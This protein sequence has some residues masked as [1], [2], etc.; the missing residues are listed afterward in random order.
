MSLT[1]KVNRI[2]AKVFLDDE[3][4]LFFQ[5]TYN[6]DSETFIRYEPVLC[7]SCGGRVR[8]SHGPLILDL[9]G[10]V[11]VEHCVCGPVTPDKWTQH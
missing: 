1:Q 5:S 4:Y 7:D 2:E 3:G 10:E 9:S 8:T 6:G 11:K